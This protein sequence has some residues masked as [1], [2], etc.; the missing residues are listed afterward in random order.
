MGGN[1][2]S[3]QTRRYKT[4]EFISVFNDIKNILIKKIPITDFHLCDFYR[5]KED[6]GD[7]DILINGDREKIADILTLFK[8][9]AIHGNYP[10]VSFNY[11]DLQ[12]DL[13][14]IEN[15]ESWEVAKTYYSYND[16]GLLMGKVIKML[17]FRYG[18]N[19]LTY[20]GYNENRSSTYGAYTISKDP[21]KIFTFSGFDYLRYKKGF[22]DLKDIFDFVIESKY[23]AKS[24]FND[25]NFDSAENR[26]DK[27]RKNFLVFLDYI[28]KNNFRNEIILP[29]EKELIDSAEI[30][31]Q[32]PI[33][34]WLIK[35]QAKLAINR[36]ISTKFNGRIIMQE[37]DIKGPKLGQML[38]NFYAI[39]GNE[40]EKN[41]FIMN[42]DISLLLNKFKEVNKLK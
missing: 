17:H 34:E 22:N 37:M 27:K 31:F 40:Q 2:L 1:A 3:I 14:A 23:F 32:S 5:N 35:K 30:F 36:E 26:R 39:F 29:S 13:V 15:P 18:F 19:G 9:D 4:D 24:L 7:M 42:N 25:G 8:Y 6:H 21:E 20:I 41:E 38:N 11:N 16:L 10:T 33:N 12:V 28:A